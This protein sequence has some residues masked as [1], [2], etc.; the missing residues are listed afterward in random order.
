MWQL[1][2]VFGLMS[3]IYAAVVSG[4]KSIDAQVFIERYNEEEE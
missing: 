2:S 3:P 1:G 4:V